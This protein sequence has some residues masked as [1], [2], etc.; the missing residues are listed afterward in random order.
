M[1]G[2]STDKLRNIKWGFRKKVSGLISETSISSSILRIYQQLTFDYKK[3][4][5]F[6]MVLLRLRIWIFIF[7][8]KE[9]YL[10][11]VSLHGQKEKTRFHMFKSTFKMFG[12]PSPFC[13]R[14][15]F[16]DWKSIL[17]EAA[18]PSFYKSISY[19][20]DLISLNFSFLPLITFSFQF[21]AINQSMFLHLNHNFIKL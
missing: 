5:Y 21:T 2:S 6:L 20:L 17:K 16:D 12:S 14:L 4:E 13:C 11:R 7:F 18:I 1:Y 10:V 3:N 19:T 15:A 8:L 9:W